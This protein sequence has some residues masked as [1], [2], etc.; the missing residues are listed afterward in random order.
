MSTSLFKNLELLSKKSP[1]LGQRICEVPSTT[2]QTA[3]TEDGGV[4]FVKQQDGE[5]YLPLTSSTPIADAQNAISQIEDRI[6]NGISP[7]VVVGLNPGYVLDIIYKHVNEQYHQKFIPRRIYVIIDSLECLYG[8]LKLENRTSLLNNEY[9]EFYH[10]DEVSTIVDLCKEDEQRSHLFTPV[11]SLPESK[12]MGIIEPLASF[13]IERQEEEIKLHE[14]N[15]KYY[16][17]QTDDE[18]D[19]ILSGSGNRKPR[20]LIPSHAS[21]TVVQYSVRDTKV[22]FEKEGWE[23]NIIHMK[24]D[25]SKW[26]TAK[27]IND[28]KPDIYMLVN[29]LR[30]EENDFYP[31][32]MMFITWV[33]DTVSYINNSENAQFWNEH[34]QSKSKRRDLIIGYVGQIKEYGYLENRLE[35]CPMIVNEDIFKA[36]KLTEEEKEKYE[37]DICFASNRSKETSLIVKEDLVPKLVKY[38]FTEEILMQVHSHLWKWYRAEHTCTSYQELLIK[39]TELPAVDELFKNLSEKNDHDFVAQRLFWELNDVI[40]RH[41][42]LEWLDQLGNIKLNLYG[43]GWDIHPQFAKYAKGTLEH[44]IELNKAY[45]G[46]TWCLHLNSMEGQHQRLN[47]VISS[48]CKS[49]V[50]YCKPQNNRPKK[51]LSAVA[52]ILHSSP[53]ALDLTPLEESYMRSFFFDLKLRVQVTREINAL[54]NFQSSFTQIIS[55]KKSIQAVHFFTNSLEFKD[56]VA[57]DTSNKLATDIELDYLSDIIISKKSSTNTDIYYIK[58]LANQT[59]LS[60]QEIDKSPQDH[61]GSHSLPI[62]LRLYALQ[63]LIKNK[64][65]DL[66]IKYLMSFSQSDFKNEID[67]T[68]F[69]WFF[70]Q[71]LKTLQEQIPVSNLYRIYCLYMNEE[72]KEVT[73][74]LI[75]WKLLEFC[76]YD[77]SLLIF[78]KKTQSLNTLFCIILVLIEIGDKEQYNKL[79][80]PFKEQSYESLKV[81]LQLFTSIWTVIGKKA[82]ALSTLEKYKEHPRYEESFIALQ[83]YSKRL[84]INLNELENKIS[85][86]NSQN[87]TFWQMRLAEH[88]LLNS[89]PTKHSLIIS[90]F[91]EDSFICHLHILR[92]VKNLC[93]LNEI[94]KAKTIIQKQYKDNPN[95]QNGYSTIAYYQ[96]ST[97]REV[98]SLYEKDYSS[99]R[100]SYI[101]QVRYAQVL[102][103]DGNFNKANEIFSLLKK[104]K[105]PVFIWQEEFNTLKQQLF[106]HA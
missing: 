1:L 67:K 81:D 28:F 53:Q 55:A 59:L 101:W 46:A 37:C 36:R 26:R 89:N 65:F 31:P 100:Q 47:E 44:G 11:S 87:K 68:Y 40:Y 99:Q 13:F 71:N 69:D 50:R 14:E 3:G 57:L 76:N 20:M 75:A 25:L 2:I 80:E 77:E 38:G 30:T 9:I 54:Q 45:N 60:L 79:I 34:V 7:I 72:Q 8:W 74:N 21:S 39:I 61:I 93:F 106:N 88:I 63:N 27:H 103:Q 42:V 73:N 18:L 64:H 23:V 22:M 16:E 66:T 104:K 29:H 33:Q 102:L 43:R 52:K 6:S 105:N 35:E 62:I 92:Y 85:T 86:L 49:L 41:A 95:Y 90:Q 82:L 51:L 4:C 70:C 15:C 17:S 98:I 78:N 56:I 24:T 84:S 48:N 12:V 91:T 83:F 96:Q 94:E 5:S 97:S 32:E 19:L 58:E 10:S